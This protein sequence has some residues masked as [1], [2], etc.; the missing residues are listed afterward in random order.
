MSRPRA[1]R[2]A[3]RKRPKQARSERLVADI[4][5]AAV[6]VLERDGAAALHHGPRRGAGRRQRRL[7]LPVLPQQAVDPLPLAAGRVGG[8]GTVARWDLRGC[9]PRRGRTAP[10][11]HDRLLPNRSSTRPPSGARWATPRP[12]IATPRRRASTAG[13]ECRVLRALIGRGGARHLPRRRRAFAAELYIATHDVDG[14]ARL[15]DRPH[16]APRST[17]SQRRQPICFWLICAS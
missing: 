1:A 6:R 5:Q 2:I 12:S 16:A 17:R 15:R 14:Q 4:L 3:P 11:R 8:D 13:A 10:R 9:A 7:A